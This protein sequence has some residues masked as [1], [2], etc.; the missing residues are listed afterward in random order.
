MADKKVK[1]I[2]KDGLD[3][4][5]RKR[6]LQK[7]KCI[8]LDPYD[9]YEVGNDSFSADQGLLPAVTY[10]D[11]VNYFINTKSPYT[12]E[13]LKAVKSLDAYNQFVNGWVKDVLSLRVNN[14]VLVIGRV[15]Y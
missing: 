6:Y 15:C 12:F 4:V 9:Y 14:M 1:V 8:G 7:I 11:I 3:N 13:Q 10:M 5:T 2:Y